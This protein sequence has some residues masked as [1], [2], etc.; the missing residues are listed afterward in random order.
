M[1]YLYIAIASI[2]LFLVITHLID[3]NNVN[4]HKPPLTIPL[5]AGLFVLC[6]VAT[7]TVFSLMTEEGPSLITDEPGHLPYINQEIETGFPE[8]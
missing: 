5:K 7:T 3:K 8:F 4:S 1:L 2:I 6:F